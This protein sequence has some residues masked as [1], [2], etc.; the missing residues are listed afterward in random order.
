MPHP[1]RCAPICTTWA[2]ELLSRWGG[3]IGCYEERLIPGTDRWS[4]HASGAA[5]DWSYSDRNVVINEVLPLFINKS[6]ELGVQA[7][8]DEGFDRIWRPPGTNGRPLQPSPECGW[9]PYPFTSS[10]HLHIECLASRWSDAR[11]FGDIDGVDPDDPNEP[12]GEDQPG[13]LLDCEIGLA[14]IWWVTHGHGEAR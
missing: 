12:P 3:E 7:V 11:P 14:E 1:G 4:T 8:H 2:N 9:K 5:I 10:P 13:T 6:E